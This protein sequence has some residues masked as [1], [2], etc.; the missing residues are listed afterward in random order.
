[1]TKKVREHFGTGVK[2]SEVFAGGQGNWGPLRS[3]PAAQARM[4]G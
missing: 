2:Q 3:G 4:V 1:M